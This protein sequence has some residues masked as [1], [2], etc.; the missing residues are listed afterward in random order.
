MRA[1]LNKICS[2]ESVTSYLSTYDMR[3]PERLGCYGDLA[4]AVSWCCGEK[5]QEHDWLV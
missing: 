4:V 5:A 1:P 2:D 3:S